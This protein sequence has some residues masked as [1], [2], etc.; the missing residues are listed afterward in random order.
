MIVISHPWEFVP[1]GSSQLNYHTSSMSGGASNSN[2][3]NYKLDSNKNA[4][5]GVNEMQATNSNQTALFYLHKSHLNRF[6]SNQNLNNQR[7]SNP[8]DNNSSLSDISFAYLHKSPLV[9]NMNFETSVCIKIDHW[10]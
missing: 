2:N 10:N 3:S 9:A 5:C 7:N 8:E 1:K 4:T 6:C